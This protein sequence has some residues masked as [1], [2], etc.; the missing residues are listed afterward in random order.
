MNNVFSFHGADH[1]VGTTQIAQ[2]CAELLA[3][4]YPKTTVLL[5]Q[6]DGGRGS[7]YCN[8]VR[9]SVEKIRPFL[10][11]SIINI[12]D[13]KQKSCYKDNLYIIGGQDHPGNNEYLTPDMAEL[14]V[15]AVRTVFDVIIIDTGCH[16]EDPFAL[17]A[18]L[19]SDKVYMVINQT[20]SSLRRY[21]WSSF[22]FER[23]DLYFDKFILNKYD[24]NSI[25]EKSY[26]ADRL[27]LCEKGIL[28]VKKCKDGNIAETKS[29]SLISIK[30]SKTL[31]KDIERIVG[32]IVEYAGITA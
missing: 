27:M 17:G 4:R 25:Y 30:E 20:E 23:V 15:D 10:A 1:K 18:A 7:E 5:I 26:I 22:L 21:E 8:H 9:E 31:I 3:K 2:C 32:D 29:Q 11:Q 12:D 14:L 13:I 24:K 19:S 28:T 16:I 6:G